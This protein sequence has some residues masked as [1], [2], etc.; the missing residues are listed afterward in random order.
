MKKFIAGNYK[1]NFYEKEYEYKNFSP[2]LINRQFEC[3]DNKIYALLIQSERQLARLN[4]YSTLIPDIDFFIFMHVRKEAETSSRI[5]GTRTEI[6][7]VLLPKNEIK[8]EKRNDWTEVQNYIKAINFA[9]AE[10]KNLPL[11]IRLLNETHEILLSKVRGSKRQPGQIRNGPNWIGGADLQNASF[12]PPNYLEV[13]DLLS[14]IENFWH[15]KKID[16]PELIRIAITHYQFETIHPYFDGNGRIGRLL[17]ALQLIDY[18]I[19]DKPTLY[20]SDFFEKN[21]GLYYDFLTIVRQTNNIEQ[22]IKFFL[23]GVIATAEKGAETFR[24][25]IE[26]RKIYDEKVRSFGSRAERGGKL[27]LL[28][29]SRPIMSINNVSKELGISYNTANRLMS[30]LLESDMVKVLKGD[31]KTRFYLLW[32]YLELF[33]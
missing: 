23:S 10:L 29:F 15:N 6:K 2:N 4:A 30:L 3:N 33:H 32:E 9:V 20:I 26:L 17:I 31:F 13:P 19:L 28:M 25:I 12:I 24:K 8:P 11:C 21:K 16:V 1:T 7:E 14:D 27:L 18:K 22:W 5:E